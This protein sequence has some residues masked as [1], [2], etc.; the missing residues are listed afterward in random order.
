MAVCCSWGQPAQKVEVKTLAPV[1]TGAAS[2]AAMA[3]SSPAPGAACTTRVVLERDEEDGPDSGEAAEPVL[4]QVAGSVSGD[5]AS[6]SMEEQGPSAASSNWSGKQIRFM[7]SNEHSRE[8]EGVWDSTGLEGAELAIVQGD[9]KAA[10]WLQKLQFLRGLLVD[11]S[12][13]KRPELE[14]LACSAIYLQWVATGAIP[15]VEGGGH[16]RPNHHAET[17]KIIFR[18]LEWVI[19]HPEE[20]VRTRLAARMVQ[21]QLP[22]FSGEF[23][24]SVPLTSIRDLAHRSD[25]P[26]ELKQELKH[27]LQNKLHRNAGPEDLVAAEAMLER[28]T[29]MNKEGQVPDA[30]LADYQAFISELQD[31]FSAGSLQRLLDGIRPSL[32]EGSLAIIDQ[33]AQAKAR[34]DLAVAGGSATMQALLDALHRVTTVRALLVAG[35]STGLRNDAPDA[36]LVMRQRWRLAEGRCQEYA[37]MLLSRVANEIDL[38]GGSEALSKATDR[39]W[40]LPIGATV[41]GLRHMGLQGLQPAEALAIEHELAL[42][43][44]QGGLVDRDNALRMRASLERCLR[45][46]EGFSEVLIE[47]FTARAGRLGK[48][49]GVDPMRSVQGL[50][51][52]LRPLVG[53]MDNTAAPFPRSSIFTESE[54]RASV[55]F[56]LSKLCEVLLRACRLAAGVSSWDTVVGGRAQGRLI[57]VESLEPAFTTSLQEDCVLVVRRASGD[58]EVSPLGPRVRGVVLRQTLPHLSHLGVR[59]RQEG[60]AFACMDDEGAY[61]QDVSPLLGKQVVLD[62]SGATAS[63][64]EAAADDSGTVAA[65]GAVAS[66]DMANGHGSGQTPSLLQW[67]K[68]PAP[69]AAVKLVMPLAEATVESCGS[70]TATCGRLAQL[71]GASVTLG[72]FRA[73]RGAAVSFDALQHVLR[74][75]GQAVE[76]AMERLLGSLEASSS[77][78]HL[79]EVE[80]V[81]KEIQELIQ[82]LQVPRD[83][84]DAIVSEL[85]RGGISGQDGGDGPV[86]ICRSSANVEDL[87]G[88]SGAGLYDSIPDTRLEHGSLSASLKGVWASLYTRRAALSRAAAGVG[89]RGARMGVLV[90]EMLPA[91]LSFVLHTSHPITRAEGTLVAEVAV[92]LGETLASGAVRGS[93]WRLE[94][95]KGSQK[96]TMAAFANFSQALTMGQ[97]ANSTTAAARRPGDNIYAAPVAPSQ[98]YG[99]RT[100]DYSVQPLS[101]NSETRQSFAQRLCNIGMVLEGQF[102]GAQD[103][104]GCVVGGDIF[105]V[106]TRPQP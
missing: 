34:A 12:P 82:G 31:F 77:A 104:E 103:V 7:R 16:Y 3:V 30:F 70:K 11:A 45:F 43:Q 46:T 2:P 86:V 59:A 81:C 90:Q 57:E 60:M 19:G 15:C 41:L 64:K 97:L 21:R 63:L 1:G 24:A 53:S 89:H 9:E 74:S 47:L 56:Q 85:G 18:S 75:N 22:A 49:L 4:G 91:D 80:G 98:K 105:I 6:G 38:M 66:R 61:A 27:T 40:A 88:L 78:G 5:S 99:L 92:G 36:A 65:K 69:E 35:L 68:H 20:D 73:P 8:R 29:A 48:A 87:A 71:S 52:S 32:D 23:T 28:I 95:D 51:L 58:E 50:R 102:G 62:C 106:Q 13:F 76:E 14:A 33:F 37:F 79:A 72:T 101:V 44:R 100:V 10:S 55:A 94:V 17:A 96:A 25:I 84:T 93:P 26:S 42:W 83:L 54:V 67:L 39:S